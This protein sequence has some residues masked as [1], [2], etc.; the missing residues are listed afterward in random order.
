MKLREILIRLVKKISN[1]FLVQF[2]SLE[3]SSRPFH[4]L[5]NVNVMTSVRFSCWF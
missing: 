1:I 3:T 5:E 2:G 4:D